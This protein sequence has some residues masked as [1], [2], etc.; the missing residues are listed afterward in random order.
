MYIYPGHTGP[1]TCMLVAPRSLTLITGSFDATI[2]LWN[3]MTG[4][5]TMVFRRVQII[6]L[7]SVVSIIKT[8]GVG[9][10]RY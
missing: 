5:T 3:I 7:F 8:T 10:K 9:R 6:L 1:V 2:R 4:E